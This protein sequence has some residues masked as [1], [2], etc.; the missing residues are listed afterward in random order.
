MQHTRLKLWVPVGGEMQPG[1]TPLEAAR[2]E[3]R[4]ETGV[5]DAT[6]PAIHKVLGA[7]PGLLLYEE[8]ESGSKGLHMNFAFV[9]EVLSK[10]IM[11]CS[12]YTGSMWVESAAKAPTDC[13]AN[14]KQ[15]LPFAITAGRERLLVSS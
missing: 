6:F 7:P 14:V 2:R 10:Q 15:A 3:L 12:E 4:E 11:P 13:P 5:I 1:E 9:A 8:H